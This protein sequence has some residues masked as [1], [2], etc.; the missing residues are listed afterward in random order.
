[1]CAIIILCLSRSPK[2]QVFDIHK[3]HIACMR[4]QTCKLVE[5]FN[6]SAIKLFYSSK[7]PRLNSN[8]NS[9]MSC[10]W[11]IVC[12][13]RH[14]CRIKFW[15]DLILLLL[16]NHHGFILREN[17][18][19]FLLCTSAHCPHALSVEMLKTWLIASFVNNI[20]TT[21]ISHNAPAEVRGEW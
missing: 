7:F 10:V 13:P 15:I 14:V 11:F 2:S 21:V 17:T 4:C 6:V 8:W 20:N 9:A 19:T 3:Q 5:D 12:K 16:S 18:C 1:M